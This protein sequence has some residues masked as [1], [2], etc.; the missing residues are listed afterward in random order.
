MK[1]IC[2][3]DY[4]IGSLVTIAVVIVA[5]KFLRPISAEAK[6]TVVRYSQSHIYS[7]MAPILDYMPNSKPSR[8]SQAS[9]YV[10]SSYVKV[11]I[12]ES[13]AY[14]IKDN[15]LYIAEMVDGEVD[16][17]TTRQVDTMSMDKV[18]LEKTMFIVEKLREGQNH[19]NGGTGKPK[20]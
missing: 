19:D 6:K 9:K 20:L 13:S 15:A 12:V 2:D 16:K 18:E 5:N 14:W 4:F 1:R 10:Q 17:E 8:V 3:L 11:M 7:L